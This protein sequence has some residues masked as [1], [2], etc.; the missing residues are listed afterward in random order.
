MA[1]CSM[2]GGKG[3]EPI[4]TGSVTQPVNVQQPLPPTLAYSDAN[5]IGQAAAAALSQVD[6]GG[7]TQEWVNTATGSSGTVEQ[8]N[9][10]PLEASGDCRA[11]STIVT[12]ISGVHSYSGDVCQS[13]SGRPTVRIDEQA[14]EVRS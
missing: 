12:S 13:G 9:L 14:A 2:F 10:A 4:T 3:G 6:G 8:Y 7:P 1:G 5:K 11:F